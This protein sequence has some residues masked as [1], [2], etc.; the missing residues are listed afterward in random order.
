[1]YK[2]PESQQQVNHHITVILSA[3]TQ[4]VAQIGQALSVYLPAADI[5]EVVDQLTL[6]NSH[7]SILDGLVNET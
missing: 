4:S 1:M 2:K 3:L 5:D 7:L 6:V